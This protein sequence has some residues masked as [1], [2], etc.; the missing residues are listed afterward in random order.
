MATAIEKIE[1][2]ENIHDDGTS[3]KLS[4]QTVSAKESDTTMENGKKSLK[5]SWD[6]VNEMKKLP[7]VH[8]KC[9]FRRLNDSETV[10]RSSTAINFRD[11]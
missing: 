11:D 8:E 3:T 2:I 9:K 7:Q 5:M 6:S 10:V 4:D 1:K